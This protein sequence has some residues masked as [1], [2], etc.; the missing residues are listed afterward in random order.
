MVFGLCC[1]FV[2]ALANKLSSIFQNIEIPNSDSSFGG[3]DVNDIAT[4]EKLFSVQTE[5]FSRHIHGS[6]LDTL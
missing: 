1:V 2:P 6:M 5:M 4:V 3:D